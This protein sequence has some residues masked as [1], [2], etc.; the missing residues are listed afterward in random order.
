MQ[1]RE[2]IKLT[3]NIQKT[4]FISGLNFKII[5]G[6]IP[7]LIIV[8]VDVIQTLAVCSLRNIPTV[9][10]LAMTSRSPTQRQPLPAVSSV[11]ASQRV[12]V[13]CHRTTSG[14]GPSQPATPTA[15]IIWLDT[16]C[17]LEVT[18]KLVI[19]FFLAHPVFRPGMS[20]CR[21]EASV[22]CLSSVCPH[23]TKNVSSRQLLM[24]FSYVCF[25]W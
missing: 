11:W 4:L 15:W 20:Y 19:D 25:V 3:R 23:F 6:N 16:T 7:D 22:V 9:T 10:A 24:D 18:Y 17:T 2:T 12:W 5:M 8:S 14:A 13:S 21:P 1:W